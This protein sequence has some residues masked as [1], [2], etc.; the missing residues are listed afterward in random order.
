MFDTAKETAEAYD[1]AALQEKIS[2]SELN[3][4]E[5]MIHTSKKD[6]KEEEEEEEEEE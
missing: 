4:P 1:Q 2:R 6:D 5:D 3:F